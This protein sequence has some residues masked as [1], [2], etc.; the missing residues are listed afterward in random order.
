MENPFISIIIATKNRSNDL[1]QCINSL[2]SQ[3]DVDFSFEIIVVNDHSVSEEVRKYQDYVSRFANLNILFLSVPNGKKGAVIARNLG[4]QNARGEVIGLLD[5]DAVPA[6]NWLATVRKYFTKYPEI[7][8]ITGWIEA[9]ELKHP[10]SLFRQNFYNLR[11]KDIQRF[12][13]QQAIK[14]RF[15]ITNFPSNFILI[16]NLSGGNSAI[17]KTVLDNIGFFDIDFD[18]MHDKDLAFRCMLNQHVC[19]FAPDLCI[20]HRHTKSVTDVLTKSFNSGKA[21]YFL[22][23]KYGNLYNRII[24][25]P[26]RP[27]WI[28]KQAIPLVRVLKWET[29]QLLFYIFLLEYLHQTAYVMNKFW[30]WFDRNRNSQP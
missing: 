16:D 11:Y 7:G 30:G 9:L 6:Q 13:T 17:K 23:Q 26:V 5:D 10:L 1:A 15:K 27:F 2:Q 18:M 24:F 28:A 21:C 12:K 14:K 25:N 29:L 3:V 20:K 19:V 4:L 8:A 22:K